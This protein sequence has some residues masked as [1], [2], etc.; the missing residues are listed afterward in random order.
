MVV[1][2]RV[3]REG[4]IFALLPFDLADFEGHC[5]A[6]Q[7]VGGHCAADY[8]GCIAASRPATPKE[9]RPLLREL[10]RIGYTDLTV[11]QRKPRRKQ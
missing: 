1:I 8:G 11:R 10:K 9:Y 6:Y 3:D 7:A 2:F 5:T 4:V